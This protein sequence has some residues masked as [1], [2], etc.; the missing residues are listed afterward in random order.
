MVT[1]HIMEFTPEELEKLRIAEEAHYLDLEEA[2][3]LNT[4]N[5]ILKDA[6]PEM[7][8]VFTDDQILELAKAEEAHYAGMDM[9]KVSSKPP[10]PPA[11]STTLVQTPA[12]D[13]ERLDDIYISIPN[14]GMNAVKDYKQTLKRILAKPFEQMTKEEDLIVNRS[15]NLT[16]RLRAEIQADK[17][18]KPTKQP[19][20]RPSA[21]YHLCLYHQT[22]NKN[23]RILK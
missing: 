21:R 14:K 2:E 16:V 7:R 20:D 1:I 19:W 11:I 3:L 18:K 5:A 13:V 8:K 15:D 9:A 4:K 12:G 17:L 6:G 22:P 23:Y 10:E